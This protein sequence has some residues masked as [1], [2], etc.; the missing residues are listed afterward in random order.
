MLGVFVVLIIISVIAGYKQYAAHQELNQTKNLLAKEQQ[1]Y[2]KMVKA[3]PLLAGD[4][5][6]IDQINDLESKYQAK[7]GELETLKRLTVRRGF[8]QFMLGLA[9]SAPTTLWINKIKIDHDSG[10]YTVNG[11]ASEPD[12]VSE[13]MSRLATTT[14]YN[15]LVFNLFFVKTIKDH[16]YLK[17]SIA[18]TNLGPEEENEIAPK[19]QVT[20]KPKE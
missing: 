6:L 17:F 19:D 8:S 16:P 2:N 18:T 15:K 20:S 14:A 11:Y 9:E 1:S 10:S 13:L 7:T 5:T 4:I 3:Y 12:D